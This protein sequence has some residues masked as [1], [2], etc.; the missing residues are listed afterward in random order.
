M[1]KKKLIILLAAVI[2]VSAMFIGC[3]KDDANNSNESQ[4]ATDS[5]GGSGSYPI[6]TDSQGRTPQDPNYTPERNPD[7]SLG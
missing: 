3:E 4:T 2:L 1:V 6:I 5:R 7:G